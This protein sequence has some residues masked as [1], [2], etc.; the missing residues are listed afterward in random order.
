MEE[1]GYKIFWNR[2][3]GGDVRFPVYSVLIE[4][5]DGLFI[6]DTGFDLNH[7]TTFLPA[8]PNPIQ[9]L[10]QTLPAQ[11]AKAG[12][13]PDD[14]THIV[15]SHLHIDHCGGNK[16]F[17]NATIV[18]HQREFEA[19]KNPQ[20]FERIS[21]SDLGFASQLADEREDLTG[22][23]RSGNSPKFELL[24]GDVELVPG[25]RLFE[26]PGHCAGHYSLLV[27]PN[28]RAPMLF[29]GDA[30]MTPRN[31]ELMIIGSYHLDPVGAYQSLSRLK[32]ISAQYKADLFFSH[33]MESFDGYS[34]A[35]I[36]YE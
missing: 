20:P 2:G 26:T 23:A 3:P 32:E 5:D 24:S 19:A 22:S 29:T 9:S 15:N 6:F 33:H 17:P 12:V 21:Y 13:R 31:V 8:A 4:H 25:I 1:D 28:K 34:K 35:P 14:V 27:S 11:L 36:W 18:C 30:A 10:D 16:L 7:L